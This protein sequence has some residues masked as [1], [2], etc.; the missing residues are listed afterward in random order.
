M[1]ILCQ[2]SLNHGYYDRSIEWPWWWGVPRVSTWDLA[3]R[4][5]QF[6][7]LVLSLSSP[8]IVKWRK[9]SRRLPWAPLLTA[10]NIKIG[11]NIKKKVCLH[12]CFIC[13][14]CSQ[15]N[16]WIV[17]WILK[18]PTRVRECYWHFNVQYS[19][20]TSTAIW[21]LIVA[22]GMF[23]MA[24]SYLSFGPHL[25][26]KI[27]EKYEYFDPD[28]MLR[29]TNLSFTFHTQ[30]KNLPANTSDLK[31]PRADASFTWKNLSPS[32]IFLKRPLLPEF[33]TIAW[34]SPLAQQHGHHQQLLLQ[35]Q[36]S[37]F[38]SENSSIQRLVQHH[39]HRDQLPQELVPLVSN[40][41][42][43]SNSLFNIKVCFYQLPLQ[44]LPQQCQHQRLLLQYLASHKWA[45]VSSE[46]FNSPQ[47]VLELDFCDCQDM[48]VQLK[49]GREPQVT[50]KCYLCPNRTKI[51]WQTWPWDQKIQVEYVCAEWA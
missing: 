51:I 40:Y 19:S 43:I 46:D 35:H 23:Q 13:L 3:N 7:Q 12:L 18:I 28:R 32:R 42:T 4:H 17:N 45:E 37:S 36:W 33:L 22:P 34:P 41:A 25:V 24:S 1:R 31:S 6:H 9:Q 44:E 29:T 50:R 49:I 15:Q 38:T 5:W 11:Y 16:Q 39:R 47:L 48:I 27:N 20:Q 26:R 8:K 30:V 14:W 10:L 2:L 21:I